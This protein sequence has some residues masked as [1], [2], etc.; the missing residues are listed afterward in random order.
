MIFAGGRSITPR[1]LPRGG[2][3]QLHRHALAISAAAGRAGVSVRVTSPRNA[4]LA[5]ASLPNFGIASANGN[6]PPFT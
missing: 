2:A 5:G 4:Y 3:R 1:L 6:V